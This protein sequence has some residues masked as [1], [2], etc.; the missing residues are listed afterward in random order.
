M[1][2][3][4]SINFVRISANQAA[5]K[6]ARASRLQSYLGEWVDSYPPFLVN[7]LL[8]DHSY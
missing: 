6:L 7:V 4:S 3:P 8:E 1:E 2:I 5:H